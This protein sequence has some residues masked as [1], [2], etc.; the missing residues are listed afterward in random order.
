MSSNVSLPINQAICANSA[1]RDAATESTGSDAGQQ[2]QNNFANVFSRVKTDEAGASADKSPRT[3]A[4]GVGTPT[5][6]EQGEDKAD[7]GNADA[8]L[9]DAATELLLMLGGNVTPTPTPPP[10]AP[11][12]AGGAT[13]PNAALQISIPV[14]A[15]T[16]DS[17]TD[18]A[19]PTISNATATAPAAAV[20]MATPIK[21]SAA[22]SSAS[23]AASIMCNT[24]APA[25]TAQKPTPV[26]ASTA[27]S[28]ADHT[29]DA[30]VPTTP[31]ATALAAALQM[32]GPVAATA[33]DSTAPATP[34]AAAT[35]LQ[36]ASDKVAVMKTAS[37]IDSTPVREP[38]AQSQA[39][40]T[41]LPAWL[42]KGSGDASDSAPQKQLVLD[43]GQS[44]ARMLDRAQ[45]KALDK[46]STD[47][48]SNAT[49]G[50]AVN[51]AAT[52]NSMGSA[53][54]TQTAQDVSAVSQGRHELHATVGSAN[55]AAELG[56]KL[57]VLSKQD[58]PTATLHVTPA[59][60]GPVQIR[61]ET[62]QNQ[63]NVWFTADHPDT[64]SAIEQSLPKLRE[65]FS[66]QGLVLNDAGVFGDRSGQQA[67]YSSARPF[68][69]WGDGH[70]AHDEE[71]V[72]TATVRTLSLSM[73]DTYA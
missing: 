51:L 27:D 9:S 36:S 52:L 39:G 22:N 16:A 53:A 19:V 60:L 45:D 32:L 31:D 24:T 30:T 11:I 8:T 72:D 40:A 33:V 70:M 54:G 12:L 3:T 1:Q 26:I 65:M 58:T 61:I 10:P 15:N 43:L 46:S 38:G 49:S 67:A 47:D 42:L 18:V 29:A 6:P 64:R 59:D 35:W 57:V 2:K 28:A 41:A 44:F 56:N 5:V 23:R 71:S 48:R 7:T 21:V 25:S 34:D 14:T 68:S 66:G 55:W 13:A 50:D 62:Q 63:A 20:Q 73:L 4:A 37:I 17:A 69:N